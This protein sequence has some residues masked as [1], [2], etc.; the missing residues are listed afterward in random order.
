MKELILTQGK[1]A[2]VDD[3]DFDELSKNKWSAHWGRGKWYAIRN[4]RINGKC[5][6]IYL[7]RQIMKTPVNLIVDHKD[8]NGLNCQKCNMRNCTQSQNMMNSYCK[9]QNKGTSMNWCKTKYTAQINIEGRQ[10]YLGSFNTEVEAA[11]AY[12]KAA[13]I[14]FGEF[15]RLNA[16]G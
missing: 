10:I 16:V 14:Y 9:R 2:L 3:E 13:V 15:A 5:N 4:K 8:G 11:E 7:H 12:N 6:I 1:V